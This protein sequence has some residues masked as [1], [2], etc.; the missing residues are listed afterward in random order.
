MKKVDKPLTR[1]VKIKRDKTQI[2]NIRNEIWGITI[3]PA[4]IKNTIREYYKELYSLFDDLEEMDQFLKNN[5][6]LKLT[7]YKM[8][9][10]SL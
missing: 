2:V 10:L 9:C 6:V 1:L 4:V 3:Y 7:Q 5:K 8:Y